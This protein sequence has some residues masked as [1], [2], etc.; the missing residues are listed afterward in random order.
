MADRLREIP[1]K[2][3][4]WWNRFTAKQKTIL[5]CIAAGVVIAL[6]ILVTALTRPQYD[7]LAVCESTKEASQITEL[8]DGAD[9]V[10]QVSDD[11]YRIEVLSAQLSDA[12]LLLGANNIPAASYDINNVMDGGFS[13]TEADKEKKYKLYLESRMEEDL[14]RFESVKKADVQ[15][16]LPENDGTLISKEEEAFASVILELDGEFTQENA[17]AVAQFVKTALGNENANNITILDS[18]GNLLFSGEDN[19]SATGNASSQL[20]V[21]QQAENLVKNEVKKVLLGTNQFDNI[22]VASNLS[23]DFSTLERTTHNYT[24]ADGQTQGVLSHE[25]IYQADS[26]GGTS[27]VPG[28]DSNGENET[29]Y[30]MQ[31]NEYSNSS[32]TEESRDYLPNEEIVIQNIPPGLIQYADS[33][34]SVTAISYNVLREED[35]RSQGLLDG[36]SWDEYKAANSERTRLDADEDMVDVVSKAT[37]IAIENIAMVAYEEPLFLDREGLPIRPTDVI[38]IVLIV[39]I[40]GLLGFVVFRSMRGERNEEGEE[41]ALNVESLLQSTPESDLADIEVDDMSDTRKMIEKFV[42]DNPEAAA[43]LLRNWLSED[44]G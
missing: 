15:L 33:S 26:T 36:V 24:P 8:L 35:A 38:Q 14:V 40:L 4:E 11:G 17:A 20:S 18:Q 5:I 25:D 9:I 34:I 21:K 19:F 12:N 27:G 37:G 23:L 22:E 28:T 42:N 31:D 44:W 10:Y 16:S 6:A 43:N 30:M 3:L 32:V 2:V 41:E 29:G 7:L 1:K 39:L 13:T